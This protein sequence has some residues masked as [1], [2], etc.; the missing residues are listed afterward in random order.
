M[1]TMQQFRKMVNA[2]L[3]KQCGLTMD[4]LADFDLYNYYDPDL[5]EKDAREIA[6]EAAHDLLYDE[7]FPLEEMV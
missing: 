3:L 2:E 4:C 1:L 5:N 6:I 7:G